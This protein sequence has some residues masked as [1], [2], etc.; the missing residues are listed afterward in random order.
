[1][2]KI[3]FTIVLKVKDIDSDT[4]TTYFAI[5]AKHDHGLY[6][7]YTLMMKTTTKFV[8]D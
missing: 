5:K 6:F 8:M 4:T 1:M 2:C 7:E 3:L